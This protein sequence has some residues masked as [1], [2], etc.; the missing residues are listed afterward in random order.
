MA[1]PWYNK[2]LTAEIRTKSLISAMTED[3][4]KKLLRGGGVH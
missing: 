3:E 4:K 2:N 1:Q